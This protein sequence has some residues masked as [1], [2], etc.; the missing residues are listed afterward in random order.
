MVDKGGPLPHADSPFAKPLGFERES[1]CEYLVTPDFP[2][3]GFILDIPHKPP[4]QW[5]IAG[6]RALDAGGAAHQRANLGIREQFGRCSL[7][8]RIGRPGYVIGIGRP[9]GP[10]VM[11]LERYG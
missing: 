6:G 9:R 3:Q 1:R 5:P 2:A 8:K 4:V 7:D 11:M 10:D